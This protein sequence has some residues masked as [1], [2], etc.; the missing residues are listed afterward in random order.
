MYKYRIYL[1]LIRLSTPLSIF[2]SICVLSRSF[3]APALYVYMCTSIPTCACLRYMLGL[4]LC[5]YLYVYPADCLGVLV[6]TNIHDITACPSVYL[7]VCEKYICRYVWLSFCLCA[8]GSIH[9]TSLLMSAG[10]TVRGLCTC[11]IYIFCLSVCISVYVSVRL[12]LSA[13]LSF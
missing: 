2:V 9:S 10:I 11:N 1:S 13:Y 6:R 4:F 3:Y 8:C 5:L 12:Y 7:P